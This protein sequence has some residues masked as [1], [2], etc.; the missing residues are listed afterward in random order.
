MQGVCK[1][2][3]LSFAVEQVDSTFEGDSGGGL[4]F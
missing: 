2:M 3:R 1:V 4:F